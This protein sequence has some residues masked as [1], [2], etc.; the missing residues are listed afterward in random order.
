MTCFLRSPPATHTLDHRNTD[1]RAFFL[2][3]PSAVDAHLWFAIYFL[4]EIVIRASPFALQRNLTAFI[5]STRN[6]VDLCLAIITIIIEIP[7]IKHSSWFPWMTFFS[8]ARFYR[9]ILAFPFMRSLAGII[10]GSSGGLLNMIIFLLLMVGLSSL[11]V[12]QLLSGDVEADDSDDGL[13]STISFKNIYNSFLGMYQ[14][15]SSENWTDVLWNVL[16]STKAY[17]QDFVSGVILCAWFFFANFILLQ[18]FIAV[19]NEN[20]TVAESDRRRQQIQ[21]YLSKKSR[22]L[23]DPEW[24]QKAAMAPHPQDSFLGR[25]SP[26]MYRWKEFQLEQQD[27]RLRDM[28]QHVPPRQPTSMAHTLYVTTKQDLTRLWQHTKSFWFVHR[29][30]EEYNLHTLRPH[31][32]TGASPSGGGAAGSGTREGQ[33]GSD[34]EESGPSAAAGGGS[35]GGNG[36]ISWPATVLEFD[37]DQYEAAAL[38]VE[39][40]GASGTDA[41]RRGI[42]RTRTDLGLA[43]NEPVSQAAIDAEYQ[44][45]MRNDPKR[46]MMLF[47]NRYP[48]YDKT[49]WL[50]TNRSRIR[51]VCQSI[52]SPSY[53]ERIFGRRTNKIAHQT[54]RI[55]LI[56]SIVA[57]VS[58]A[59]F[60][61][62]TYRKEYMQSHAGTLGKHP[63]FYFVDALLTILFLVEI[64][65]K[66]V[67][68]GLVFTPNAYLMNGWNIMDLLVVATMLVNMTA[69]ENRTARVSRAFRP[70]RFIS[71]SK[72]IRR[73]CEHMF[74]KGIKRMIQASLLAIL[75]II[76]FA[77]WGQN[78]FAGLLYSCND[79]DDAITFKHHCQGEFSTSPVGDWSFLAPRVWANPTQGSRYSFDNFHSALLIL[80][81][82]VSLEGS[83]VSSGPLSLLAFAGCELSDIL[84]ACSTD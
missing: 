32:F 18:M 26:Y 19:I 14:V 43:V 71:L 66:V 72:H 46:E 7:A 5:T 57:S 62:P 8:L 53:G 1:A 75:Y 52:V 36:H 20:F 64:V 42:A 35:A 73:T 33:D 25:F 16:S 30:E 15:F 83:S 39:R 28:G 17:K 29:D 24:A 76:P 22:G 31:S 10:F 34:T 49:L 67:A 77:V 11:V 56:F 47:L 54:Y 60:A 9:F 2:S 61:T 59:G 69:G 80:F 6:M 79:T 58:I 41:T 4:V 13:E 78:L 63:W 55:I 81:E 27:Q 37:V 51:R 84:P 45:R 68:D 82:I 3:F 23:L 48:S 65:L 70:L 50:F 21:D 74:G 12:V 40:D 38:G 44:E